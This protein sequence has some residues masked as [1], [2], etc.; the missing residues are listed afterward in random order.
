VPV[1]VE[2]LV[3]AP[4][5]PAPSAPP[6]ATPTSAS[7][8]ISLPADAQLFVGEINTHSAGADRTFRSPPLT[9]GKTY[10]Y[11]FRAELERDGRVITQTK[12]VV[13]QAGQSATVS[14][15]LDENYIA[16]ASQR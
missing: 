11:E 1:Q 12:Q 8:R 6:A 10:A 15:D 9:E 4:A 3:P 2:A 13:I 5:Q 7:L 14:F 16:Q